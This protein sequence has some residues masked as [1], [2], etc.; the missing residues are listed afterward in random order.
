MKRKEKHHYQYKKQ[1]HRNQHQQMQKKVIEIPKSPKRD[2][3]SKEENREEEI[4]EFTIKL[5]MIFFEQCDPKKCTGKKLQKLGLLSET[6]FYSSYPGIL[7]TPTGKK[8]VSSEDA[9]IIAENGICVLDCSWAKFNELKLNFS[10]I[11]TRSLP[12]MVAVNPVNYGKAYKLTCAEAIAATLYLGGFEKEAKFVM[13]HFKWGP[14]F[15]DVNQEVFNMYKEAKSQEEIKQ[16]EEKYINDEISSKERRKNSDG[17]GELEDELKREEEEE[18][19]NDDENEENQE[20]LMNI[21]QNMDVDKLT[22]QLTK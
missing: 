15:F 1:N 11:E 3:D 12:Y 6:K 18:G 2:D 20:A 17:L 4:D 19:E 14:S 8:I 10:K 22:E 9:K 21:W 13:N 5:W 16:M 7:L